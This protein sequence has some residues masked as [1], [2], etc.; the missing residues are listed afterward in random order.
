MACDK[1]NYH[2]GNVI[3]FFIAYIDGFVKDCFNSSALAMGLLQSHTEP[4]IW[5]MLKNAKF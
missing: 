1:W 3:F 5:S 4:S 2:A